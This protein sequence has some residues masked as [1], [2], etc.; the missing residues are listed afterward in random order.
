MVQAVEDWLAEQRVG[1]VTLVTP[2][3]LLVDIEAADLL[4]DLDTHSLVR[5]A[6]DNFPASRRSCPSSSRRRTYSAGRGRRPSHHAGR[7]SRTV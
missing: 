4:V 5:E 6:I 1:L 7:L 2:Q 3:P